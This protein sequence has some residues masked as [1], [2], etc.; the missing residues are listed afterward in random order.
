M[1]A[2]KNMLWL[3]YLL[4]LW[5]PFMLGCLDTS[6]FVKPKAARFYAERGFKIVGYQGYNTHIGIGRCYWYTLERDTLL[7]QSCLTKW[8]D[9][10]HE[11]GLKGI[12]VLAT[13]D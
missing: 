9:E 13:R 6:D 8:G 12:G 1:D 11:Y 5:L 4:L 10:V 3:K 7:Y 2:V